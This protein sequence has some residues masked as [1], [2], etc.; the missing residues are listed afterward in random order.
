MGINLSDIWVDIQFVE[1]HL[2]DIMTDANIKHHFLID[3][4]HPQFLI[5]S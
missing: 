4:I 1:Y 2:C 5:K 3:G